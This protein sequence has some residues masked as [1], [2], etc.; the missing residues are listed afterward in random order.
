MM[1]IIIM[2]KI[3]TIIMLYE[4]DQNYLNCLQFNLKKKTMLFC[5]RLEDCHHDCENDNYDEN[6]DDDASDFDFHWCEHDTNRCTTMMM[7]IMTIWL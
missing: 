3:M 5:W 7:M 1:V 4:D 6:Y 2:I